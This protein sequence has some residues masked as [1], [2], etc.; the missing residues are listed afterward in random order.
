MKKKIT[1]SLV[2][3]ACVSLLAGCTTSTKTTAADTGTQRPGYD[4]SNRKVYTKEELD[5][6][7]RQTPGEDLAAQDEE[8]TYTGRH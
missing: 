8:I 1:I 4:A 7:G 2:T 6:R 3:A 5:K